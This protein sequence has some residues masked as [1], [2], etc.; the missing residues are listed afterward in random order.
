MLYLRCCEFTVLWMWNKLNV[1]VMCAADFLQWFLALAGLFALPY[2]APPWSWARLSS[3]NRDVPSSYHLQ[4]LHWSQVYTACNLFWT[5][6]ISKC[7]TPLI[8]L[9]RYVLW[10][11][12]HH[13]ILYSV[14]F[15]D[16]LES[17]NKL[18][19]VSLNSVFTSAE[20]FKTD[21]DQLSLFK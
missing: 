5:I 16:T 7:V 17:P 8:E 11:F 14:K 6:V 18:S 9:N 2:A 3:A 13:E 10:I 20:F 19:P 1:R 4:L 12:H 15:L 21:N